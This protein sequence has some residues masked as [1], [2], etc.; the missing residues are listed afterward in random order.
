MTAK[1]AKA[2]GPEADYQAGEKGAEADKAADEK[3]RVL[4]AESEALPK[5]YPYPG[6]TQSQGTRHPE[7]GFI[8][9]AVAADLEMYGSA[10]DPATGRRFTS[11]DLEAK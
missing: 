7:P 11:A 2:E 5:A 1:Q 3:L 6:D 10:V 9:A 8:S 4:T